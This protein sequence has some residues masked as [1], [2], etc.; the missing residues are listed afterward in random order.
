MKYS[1]PTSWMIFAEFF[2]TKFRISDIQQPFRLTRPI[3]RRP[4]SS[5]VRDR[6]VRLLISVSIR[7]RLVFVLGIGFALALAF[8]LGIRRSEFTFT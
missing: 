7:V 5:G 4:G 3:S 2:G 8:A 6:L 1:V